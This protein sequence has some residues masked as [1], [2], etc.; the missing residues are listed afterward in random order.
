M[1]YFDMSYSENNLIKEECQKLRGQNIWPQEIP[2]FKAHF[3]EYY[4]KMFL[5]GKSL[6]RIFAKSFD[7]PTDY[8]E[9]HVKHPPAQLRLLHYLPNHKLVGKEDVAMGG[10]TDY[11]LFTLL[12]QNS[13]GI[14]GYSAEEKKFVNLPVFKNTLLMVVGD[15][16][17]FMTNGY[18]KSFYHR[19]INNGMKRLSFPFFMNLDFETELKVLPKFQNLNAKNKNRKDLP[20]SIVVGHHLLGQLYRDF[21]Y[22]KERIDRGEWKI[23][24]NI[25]KQ[26][27]FEIGEKSE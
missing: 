10:H 13:P 8:F 20:K 25:P 19:V 12:H 22:I 4:R 26:N 5:L 14:Q 2:E 21:P 27:V 9:E 1:F 24:F 6:L 18:L 17:H 3:E 15:M 16:M 7:L 11:E 23:P